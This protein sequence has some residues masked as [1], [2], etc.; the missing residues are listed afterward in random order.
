MEGTGYINNGFKQPVYAG[1]YRIGKNLNHS[2]IFNITYK[3]NLIHRFFS[4]LFL[5]WQWI[6]NLNK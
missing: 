5:G 3:P 4:K 6:D 1:G 2:V